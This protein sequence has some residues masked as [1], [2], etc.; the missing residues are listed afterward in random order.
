MNESDR[1][2]GESRIGMFF[3]HISTGP[4]NATFEPA[5]A[6]AI[7]HCVFT[8]AAAIAG[9]GIWLWKAVQQAGLPDM[10]AFGIGL[11]GV[12]AAVSAAIAAVGLAAG[13]R[14]DKDWKPRQ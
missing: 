14:G 6:M 1:R 4:D 10:Q 2:Q 9:V 5:N 11:A 13:A 12:G 8:L 7:A 3:R